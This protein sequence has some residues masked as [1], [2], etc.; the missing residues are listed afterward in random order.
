[1][2]VD[3]E[4]MTTRGES[5]TVTAPKTGACT[6]QQQQPQPTPN[7]PAHRGGCGSSRPEETLAATPLVGVFVV[8][9]NDEWPHD[10][11]HRGD[12]ALLHHHRRHGHGHG[13]GPA[14][15][16]PAESAAAAAVVTTDFVGDEKATR[17]RV[18]SRF[19][20]FLQNLT[21]TPTSGP[22]RRRQPVTV[23]L[24]FGGHGMPGYFCLAAG[25]NDTNNDEDEDEED[26]CGGD[27]E[28]SCS[29]VATQ[30][31][32]DGIHD[33]DDGDDINDDDEANVW[34]HSDIVKTLETFLTR[35]DHVW[36][37]ADCCYSGS[38]VDVFAADDWNG[39][40]ITNNNNKND[41]WR[42][43]SYC[44][45]MSTARDS[46]A[47][48]E[49]TLTETW[50]QA[51][52]GK[53][54]P[55]THHQLSNQP[56]TTSA[57]VIS[58]IRKRI[59]RDKGDEMQVLTVGDGIRL[60]DPF[61][62]LIPGNN[63]DSST[64]HEKALLC[65]ATTSTT[66]GWNHFCCS[67][68]KRQSRRNRQKR[69]RRLYCQ[70]AQCLM[71]KNGQFRSY[72]VPA[73]TTVWAVWEDHEVLYQGTVLEDHGVPWEEVIRSN[74][75]DDGVSLRQAYAGPLGPFVPIWW[76]VE[77]T[78]SLVPLGQCVTLPMDAKDESSPTV[79]ARVRKQAKLAAR[80]E[81][82]RVTLLSLPS[83][84]TIPLDAMLR[85]FYS[86]GKSLNDAT[87]VVGSAELL[88]REVERKA[89][90]P[91]TAE[92]TAFVSMD[93]L[94]RHLE[95]SEQGVYCIVRCKATGRRSCLPSTYIRAGP[96][97][98]RLHKRCVKN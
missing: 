95:Y 22:R 81:L 64:E 65:Q 42:K 28:T 54:D 86:A 48:S 39:K 82:E 14:K 74:D 13:S 53:F 7:P 51:M 20:T 31:N 56:I 12:I 66:V 24:Y 15:P 57:Q 33:D 10:R 87:A 97:A 96:V 59:Q 91:A 4:I 34:Y 23:V 44:I 61:P 32:S 92:V 37:L 85:S 2:P 98:K 55:T 73:G 27:D 50:I 26:R 38:F 80:Q 94:V 3:S 77:Q 18:R 67:K 30:N 47:G 71:A 29:A 45:L 19:T 17:T 75:D 89:W 40:N 41:D 79:V 16:Q 68:N 52:E 93:I 88:C 70:Q 76:N 63:I 1:M 69:R 6:S 78:W 11:C 8:G 25:D 9:I 21:S 90:F 43:A 72:T 46:I 5:T 36:I 62:F 83:G 84:M 58:A 35:G 49:W 60:D